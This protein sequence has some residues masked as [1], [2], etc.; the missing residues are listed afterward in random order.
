MKKSKKPWSL[1]E[2]WMAG[3][4]VVCLLAA[5]VMA[6]LILRETKERAQAGRDQ[7]EIEESYLFEGALPTKALQGGAGAQGKATPAP[8]EEAALEDE[9]L[10]ADTALAVVM[11]NEEL[12]GGEE[13]LA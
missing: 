13:R 5:G 8:M 6:A 2:K 9:S 12:R 1:L 4:L 7:A 11:H 10:E 3:A